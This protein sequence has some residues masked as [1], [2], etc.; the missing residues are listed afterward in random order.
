MKQLDDWDHEWKRDEHGNL[1]YT[2]KR[3]EIDEKYFNR[4]NELSKE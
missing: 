4:L 3:T 2:P 1:I